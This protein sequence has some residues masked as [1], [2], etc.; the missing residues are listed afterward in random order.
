MDSDEG[1]ESEEEVPLVKN[2]L[3]GEDKVEGVM[4]PSFMCNYLTKICEDA[5]RKVLR[6]YSIFVYSLSPSPLRVRLFVIHRFSDLNNVT[7][8]RS[9][10]YAY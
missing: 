10:M 7:G 4:L 9:R 1:M 8:R 2:I 3:V 6:M 5:K